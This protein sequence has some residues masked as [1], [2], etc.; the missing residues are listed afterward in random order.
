[1]RHFRHHREGRPFTL[2]TDHKPLCGALAGSV[3]KSPRQARHL[4]YIGEFCAEIKHISGKKNVVADLLSRPETVPP[5][6]LDPLSP[7]SALLP[8]P[9]E[10]SAELGVHSVALSIGLDPA[11][12]A[13]AQAAATDEMDA[14]ATTSSLK[15]RSL[16]VG[17]PAVTLCCDVSLAQ[18][19]PVV[20]SSMVQ[21][22]FSVIHGVSHAGGKAT[23][24]ELS[25]RFVWRG[26]R[27]S[28]L[29]M[30][31]E[32]PSCQASK[33]SRHVKTPFLHREPA[34]RRFGSLHVD[35]VGPL[36]SSE[37]FTYLFTII[38]RFTCWV[39]A[40]PL[41]SMTAPDC[42]R[43][44]IRAWIARFGVPDDITSDQGRQFTSHLWAELTRSLGMKA[45][46]T[47]SYHPQANG[48]V[49]RIHR[50]LKERLMARGAAASWMD[51]LPMVLLGVRT[52][53]RADSDLCP[54]ELA[55]GTTLRLP[56]EMFVPPDPALPRDQSSDFAAHLRSA[57]AAIRQTPPSHHQRAG[58]SRTGVPDG[59]MK[60]PFVFVRVDAV[61]PPLARPYSGPYKVLK[62]GAKSFTVCRAGKPWT[63]SAD[64][65]KPAFGC[66]D[67]G[68]PLPSPTPA[69]APSPAGSTGTAVPVAPPVSAAA[70]TSEPGQRLDS[71]SSSMPSYSAVASKNVTRFGRVV[72]APRRYA[73]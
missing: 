55:L 16:P 31:R 7:P 68:P 20:P 50:V 36:P 33:V 63:V 17:S 15:L 38:D 48:M 58:H 39:E 42:A 47:T 3:D 21:K 72:R 6:V 62:S 43:A 59:L 37:G 49:E 45:N 11:E 2:W 4:S 27:A 52:S 13:A 29:A 44:L 57:F 70:G 60:A 56:G 46:H 73:V 54:A 23:L 53:A 5:V 35:L 69:L 40:V 71:P 64:R 51:H 34:Q 67:P 25:R 32:C 9:D 66:H 14:Y 24:R 28:V 8:P 19:R 65:L 26:M 12:L 22:V 18:P 30:A 1:M 10:D 61:R 41:A